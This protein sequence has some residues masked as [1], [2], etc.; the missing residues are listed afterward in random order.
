[1]ST[2]RPPE[3]TSTRQIAAGIGLVLGAVLATAGA[4]LLWGLAGG[5][6][7]GGLLAFILGMALAWE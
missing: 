3:E 1:M 2:P 6:L 4:A 7:L 5:L